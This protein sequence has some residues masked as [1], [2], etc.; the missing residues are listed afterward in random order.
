MEIL[1]K[2][3]VVLANDFYLKNLNKIQKKLLMNW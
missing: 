1:E 2:I 3:K